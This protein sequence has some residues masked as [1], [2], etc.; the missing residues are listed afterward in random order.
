MAAQKIVQAIVGTV[1]GIS[2][3]VAGGLQDYRNKQLSMYS[4]AGKTIGET[5]SALRNMAAP[6]QHIEDDG[7]EAQEYVAQTPEYK[8]EDEEMM[9]AFMPEAIR[10]RREIRADRRAERRA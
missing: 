3:S 4:N 9:E 10:S 1:S 8:N 6:K 2:Q 7:N 5:G